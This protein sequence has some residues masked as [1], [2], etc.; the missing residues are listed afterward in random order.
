MK[1]VYIEDVFPSEYSDL[2]QKYISRLQII[3]EQYDVVIFMARKAICF[4][5]SLLSTGKITKP[6]NC[7]VMSSRV[8]TYNILSLL[9]DK[10]VAV[11][12]D[13]VV[14]GTSIK[15]SLQILTDNNIDKDIYIVACDEHF[16]EGNDFKNRND[17]KAP[18]VVLSE[19]DI[20]KL[21]KHIIQYIEYAMCPYNIDQPLYKLR[22]NSDRDLEFFLHQNRITEITSVIQ[23]K[24]GISNYVIHFDSSFLAEYIGTSAE[25]VS[26]KIRFM[27]NVEEGYLL[28]LPFILLPE[29]E[30]IKIDTLFENIVF[31][32]LSC[33]ISNEDKDEEYENKLKVIQY[34]YSNIILHQFFANVSLDYNLKKINSNEI[35]QF[36]KVL[37]DDRKYEKK[38]ID[39]IMSQKQFEKNYQR[40]VDVNC[41]D[42]NE[43]LGLT[44]AFIEKR[45]AEGT[46]KPGER[47]T[48][49]TSYSEIV[50]NL[51][52]YYGTSLDVYAV[53][54]LIDILI[55]RG[56]LV[57]SIRNIKGGKI[58]RAYK[59]G[60]V[61]RLSH[62]Q[63]MYFV[64]M[65][66][67][68]AENKQDLLGR[69][70][71]EKLCVLF[72][73]M[74]GMMSVFPNV[75]LEDGVGEDF[76]EIAYTK[77]GPRVAK[78]ESIEYRPYE[79][80]KIEVED[81]LTLARYLTVLGYLV[82]INKK[83]QVLPANINPDNRKIIR[84]IGSFAY[85][86]DL[87]RK[88]FPSQEEQEEIVRKGV[89]E[90]NF[91]DVFSYVPT[92]TKFLTLLSIGENSSER[93]L[94]LMAEINLVARVNTSSRKKDE[95]VRSLDTAMDGV[96]NGVWKY[97]CY[98]RENLL[99]D[100]FGQ[101]CERD[102]QILR[103]S[104][105]LNS[106][107]VDDKNKE[108]TSFLKECG[109]FLYKVAFTYSCIINRD[110][111]PPF[112]NSN[113]DVLD[114]RDNIW[115]RYTKVYLQNEQAVVQDIVELI[116]EAKARINICDIFL[117][118]RAF[119][120]EPHQKLLVVYASQNTE[121]NISNL[122]GFDFASNKV[123][124]GY[125]FSI[126][127][128]RE[129]LSLESQLDNVLKK[130]GS[131][132]NVKILICNM[133]KWYEGIFN[134]STIAKGDYFE[135]ILKKFFIKEAGRTKDNILELSICHSTTTEMPNILIGEVCKY[136][137]EHTDKY[138]LNEKYIVDRYNVFV[139]EEERKVKN[140]FINCN[141]TTPIFAE[142]IEGD[143]IVSDANAS[144]K[145]LQEELELLK[146]NLSNTQVIE[147]INEVKEVNSEEE[148][149]KLATALKRAYEIGGAVVKEV[150][151]ELAVP[152]IKMLLLSQ[153]IDLGN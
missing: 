117:K 105:L 93:L 108:I 17:I 5:N 94:S 109:R 77:Y 19:F 124:K 59:F 102:S 53:S 2:I 110:L 114:L 104:I 111:L 51:R 103:S 98:C 115:K 116:S 119:Y 106:T 133:E 89:S 113:K 153:G 1:K 138:D 120:F 136:K 46:E 92:Y 66:G 145:Q 74:G 23:K 132:S 83:Y 60:E 36:S 47:Q 41:I 75:S 143:L 101:L 90:R 86:M 45:N 135:G 33:L 20:C 32:E 37:L 15:K 50:S 8:L 6:D 4:Y 112:E 10:R 95:L 123:T 72:F 151:K 28:V 97:H 39:D 48:V 40:Y 24:R 44:Y 61:V 49:L 64:S 11:I 81:A 150:L 127:R 121:N 79:R 58:L 84:F 87:F 52:Q 139:T 131:G 126:E 147:V 43:Y 99:E 148:K 140:E 27:R 35:I 57:P 73:R 12:D 14:K 65:L 128:V 68:Y 38:A 80:Q 69:T 29:L 62:I 137:L 144:Y 152:A 82:Q 63:I 146:E 34:I 7:C 78:M 122:L 16:L 141:L 42:Y 107:V 125:C 54:N 76:Y 55:D 67:M 100:I 9:R 25:E 91:V 26:V 142:K 149:S 13:V 21:S 85:D 134:S 3:L 70:E 118:E 18:Y 31:D 22:F 30:Y 129:E 56:I 88:A 71:L 130:V 96:V